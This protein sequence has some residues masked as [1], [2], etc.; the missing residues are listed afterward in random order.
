MQSKMAELSKAIEL[1]KD[2]TKLA[3]AD[4]ERMQEL[5]KD[6]ACGVR[7]MQPQLMSQISLLKAQVRQ[8]RNGLS[9]SLDKEEEE[10]ELRELRAEVPQPSELAFMNRAKLG[11]STRSLRFKT[12]AT[13][14]HGTSAGVLGPGA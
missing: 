5:L 1:S 4:S 8:V 12:K 7:E 10:A 3:K 9:D 6:T 14:V 13:H 11:S 2:A